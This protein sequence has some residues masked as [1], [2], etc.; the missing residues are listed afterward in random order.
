MLY[1]S[2]YFNAI[3]VDQALQWATKATLLLGDNGWQAVLQE[4]I[5]SFSH[6]SSPPTAIVM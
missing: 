2:V 3:T 4:A 1:C 5:L 6:I